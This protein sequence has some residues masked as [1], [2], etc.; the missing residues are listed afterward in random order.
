M[1][2]DMD[3]ANIESDNLIFRPINPDDTDLILKWRNSDFV[4][5]NFLH[6]QDITRDEHLN[7]MTEYVDKGKV[8]QFIIVEKKTD[9]PIGSVYF[10][11]VD[12]TD[13]KG[14]YGI[15]IGEESARGK[16]YGSETAK[17]M[18][19]YFLDELGFHKLSLRVLERNEIAIKSYE[20]AGFRIEGRMEDEVYFD[21][22]YENLIFMAIIRR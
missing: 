5:N 3:K 9:K 10:R 16:G 12:R 22:K 7:W 19:R 11:D 1:K 15:F 14:E 18:V 8:I 13:M 2:Q 6:R 17:R 21:G 4:K 20:N